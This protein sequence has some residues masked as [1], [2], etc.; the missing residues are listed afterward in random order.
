MT[1]YNLP[2][3]AILHRITVF[4]DDFQNNNAGWEIIDCETEHSFINDS[5]YFLENKS[6][7]HWMFYHKALTGSFPKN[8]VINTEIELLENKGY[9]QFGLLWGFTDPSHI[10]NRFVRSAETERFT[11]T[12]FE[13]NHHRSFHRFSDQFKK[14]P[15]T[16]S[17][18]FFS[19]MLLNDYYYFFL[20][21][22]QRPIY[23]CHKSH[24]Q[25]EGNR[26]GF[27]IEP[28]LTIRVD[29]IKIERLILKPDFDGHPWMPLGSETL[30][31]I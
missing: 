2:L 15:E 9:G 17:K 3:A 7:N 31:G 29:K 18:Q 13:K 27:Y 16:G 20:H 5:H 11:I 26:F 6:E 23:I 10:L 1:I 22:Y 21:K 8:F 4:E 19:I 25:S 24:M 28:G 30:K 14:E 12:R